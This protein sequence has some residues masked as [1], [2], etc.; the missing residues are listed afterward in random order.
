MGL[1]VTGV[2]DTHDWEP[3]D[4]GSPYYRCKTPGCRVS[5]KRIGTAWPPI[6]DPKFVLP[7]WATC[8]GAKQARVDEFLKKQG[9][10]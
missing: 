3:L 9:L 10:D 1:R 7:Q 8:E 2:I 5:G 6:R 4:K